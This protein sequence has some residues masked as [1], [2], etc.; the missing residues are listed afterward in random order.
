MIFDLYDNLIKGS[1]PVEIFGPEIKILDIEDNI[2]IGK[3]FPNELFNRA[4]TLTNFLLIFN[5]FSGT[6][7]ARVGELSIMV[8]FLIAEKSR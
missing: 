1:V 5:R 7:P 4:S 6:I 3:M 2:L 8:N